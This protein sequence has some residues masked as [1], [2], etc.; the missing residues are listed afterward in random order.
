MRSKTLWH[1]VRAGVLLCGGVAAALS[2]G[3]GHAQAPKLKTATFEDGTGTIGLAPGWKMSGAYRGSVQCQGPNDS[4]VALGIPWAILRPDSSVAQLPAAMQTPLA[5]SGDLIG[6][7][8]EVLGKKANATLKTVRTRP[9]APANP[10]APAVYALYE[11]EKDGKTYVALSY[12]TALD[13]GSGSPAWQEYASAIIAPKEKFTAMLPAMMAM[14]KSWKPNG[15]APLAGS[16]SAKV[17]EIIRNNY[18]S[19]D[20]IQQQFRKLL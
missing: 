20:R 10:G 6:A 9:A 13:Y 3:T 1:V 11:Y 14:W 17:D 16:E 18:K 7:L 19:L 12:L 15:R 2:A 4:L 8:R 5:M